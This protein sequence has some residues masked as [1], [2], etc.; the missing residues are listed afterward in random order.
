MCD[1]LARRATLT[2]SADP[3]DVRYPTSAQGDD[4]VW[5]SAPPSSTD[6]EARR[7][8]QERTRLIHDQCKRELRGVQEELSDLPRCFGQLDFTELRTQIFEGNDDND[9]SQSGSEDDD[10]EEE[11]EDDDDEGHEEEESKIFGHTKFAVVPPRIEPA[12]ALWT[13]QHTWK[14]HRPGAIFSICGDMRQQIHPLLQQ[15]ILRR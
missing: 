4:S 9:D 1:A 11:E 8:S 15:V 10:D 2:P 7:S 6:L 5:G 3:A 13:L 14:L 12:D